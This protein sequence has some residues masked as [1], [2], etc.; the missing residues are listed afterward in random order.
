[1]HSARKSR[2]LTAWETNVQ[3][4]HTN[5]S[6]T[7]SDQSYTRLYRNLADKQIILEGSTDT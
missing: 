6:E 3:F 7:W 1:M 5:C 2:P 4:K